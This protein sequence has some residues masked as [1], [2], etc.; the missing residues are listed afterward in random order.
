MQPIFCSYI[1]CFSVLNVIVNHYYKIL[2]LCSQ[3]IGYWILVNIHIGVTLIKMLWQHLYMSLVP[4]YV[5]L[6]M[7]VITSLWLRGKWQL[8]CG[9]EFLSHFTFSKAL[10][11]QVYHSYTIA[12][13]KLLVY[14]AW[15]RLVQNT[16]IDCFIRVHLH[17]YSIR[18]YQYLSWEASILSLFVVSST[19]CCSFTPPKFCLVHT[20]HI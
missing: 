12:A 16:T 20:L 7:Q 11:D 17:D 14:T 4:L 2:T 9:Q 10:R 15:R 3:Y 19:E 1:L 8:K 5:L 13:A 18:V 6:K